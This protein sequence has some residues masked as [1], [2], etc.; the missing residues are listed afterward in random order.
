MVACDGVSKHPGIAG[1]A[2][3]AMLFGGLAAIDRLFLGRRFNLLE[4][5][6]LLPS[7]AVLVALG[8]IGES[9]A[10]SRVASERKQR[11]EMLA[12]ALAERSLIA[13]AG[14]PL[15]LDKFNDL[16]MEIFLNTG[17]AGPAEIDKVKEASNVELYGFVK[18]ACRK[19]FE[20]ILNAVKDEPKKL[21]IVLKALAQEVYSYRNIEKHSN[22]QR[23]M[24]A[25]LDV[26]MN[27][28][29]DKL[30]LDVMAT[31]HPECLI[32]LLQSAYSEQPDKL[33]ELATTCSVDK[34]NT[35]FVNSASSPEI[36]EIML[37]IKTSLMMTEGEQGVILKALC[38]C[39]TRLARNGVYLQDI[40]KDS[41]EVDLKAHL[42]ILGKALK[43]YPLLLSLDLLE[44]CTNRD[45]KNAIQEHIKV[46]FLA[47]SWKEGEITAENLSDVL[48]SVREDEFDPH[49]KAPE[50]YH[51]QLARLAKSFSTDKNWKY[52]NRI[53]REFFEHKSKALSYRPV[54]LEVV[55]LAVSAEGVEMYAMWAGSFR[56]EFSKLDFTGCDAAKKQR[57]LEKGRELCAKVG[58][59]VPKKHRR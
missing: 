28:A 51:P 23:E 35:V 10:Y 29:Q 53:I 13:L 59:T 20:V 15:E 2:V 54:F 11:D 43:G 40:D 44:N 50:T 34:R 1:A 19:Q 47:G 33:K 22:E 46:C 39:I 45:V 26:A 57:I 9:V 8:L 41:P 52:F 25:K 31:I 21:V 5:K 37:E 49:W 36:I 7:A 24:R 30:S 27:Q 17:G 56:V 16:Q 58:V 32:P 48:D 4:A 14:E 3:G 42:A 6:K 55:E 38:G 18:Y 12:S